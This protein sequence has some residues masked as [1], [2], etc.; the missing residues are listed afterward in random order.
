MSTSP[1]LRATLAIAAA[2]LVSGCS[3]WGPEGGPGGDSSA[4]AAASSSTS[5]STETDP[6]V[7]ATKGPD[8]IQRI[9]IQAGD[10]LRYRPA[11]V[12]AH[13][14]IIEITVHN[15]GVT[16]H[17]LTFQP[18]VPGSASGSGIDNLNG[19]RTQTIR[20]TITQ[21]GRYTFQCAYH[22]TNGMQG[23]L[24]IH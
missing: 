4:T 1:A 16:P 22:A 3:T 21:P 6:A 12:T 23:T 7:A 5:P 2:A 19:G 13:P 24:D 14:G 20:I 10:D 11:L 8:G 15:T 9:T 18:P 17:T